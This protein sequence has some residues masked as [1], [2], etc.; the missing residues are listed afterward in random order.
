[1]LK[2]IMVKVAYRNYLLETINSLEKTEQEIF[3]GILNLA[4]NGELSQILSAFEVGEKYAFNIKHF[5]KS[6]DEN[7]QRLVYIYKEVAT[8]KNDLI[9]LNAV[10]EDELDFEINE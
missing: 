5:E 8:I 2:N 10:E 4:D 1:M 3:T 7:V 9:N 6:E